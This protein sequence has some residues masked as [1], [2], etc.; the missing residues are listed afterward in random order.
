VRSS[1]KTFRLEHQHG[2][3]LVDVL[4]GV[5]LLA[6]AMVVLLASLSALLVGARTAERQ[7]VEARLA[8]NEIEKFM[9][10]PVPA[11]P[12]ASVK[13]VT[14]GSTAYTIHA[15][16]SPPGVPVPGLVKFTVM[17]SEPSGGSLTLTNER[18]QV[19]R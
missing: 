4:V 6:V 9:A 2:F 1:R 11:C 14:I 12:L 18:A 19:G 16:C 3:G 5:G 7:T 13:T 17:V 8:R 10:Q 15:N